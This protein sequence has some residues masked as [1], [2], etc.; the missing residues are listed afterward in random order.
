TRVDNTRHIPSVARDRGVYREKRRM[1]DFEY[2]DSLAV[3]A[4]VGAVISALA[5]LTLARGHVNKRDMEE[6]SKAPPAASHE[7]NGGLF[8]FLL[9]LSRYL[10]FILICSRSPLVT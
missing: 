10:Y 4:T 3:A 1:T 5:L 7:P 2:Y 8:L 9:L 6:Y